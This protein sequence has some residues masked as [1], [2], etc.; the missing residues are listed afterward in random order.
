MDDIL[1]IGGSNVDYIATSEMKLKKEVSN[2]GNISISFGGVM[3]NTAENLAR[4]G[5]KCT[6]LTAIG[7]DEYGKR[8]KKDLEDLN[9]NVLTPKSNKIT[10]SYLAIND[11][12]NDMYVAIC[13]N[14]IIED[15]NVDFIEE[16]RKLIENHE[17]IIL[18]ANLDEKIIDYLFLNFKDKKFI[19]EAISPQKVLKFKKHL[20]E[21]YLLKCNIHEAQS[22]INI[23]LVEKDLVGALLIKGIKSVVVSNRANSVYYG[24]DNHDIGYVEVEKVDNFINTTGCGDALFSGI[25]DK[26][27]Q[28]EKLK[29]AVRFGNELSKLTLMSQKST[30]DEV[31]KLRYE[32]K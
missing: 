12:N 26:L 4:L 10:S 13:D 23:D 5:N 25:I 21:I 32:H 28:G 6:F 27:L 29:E 31:S 24:K 2:P 11:I 22:L 9:I 20:S 8:L 18:D 19:C 17:Y 1:L 7:N 16:N 15:L 30:S 14:K 3:R